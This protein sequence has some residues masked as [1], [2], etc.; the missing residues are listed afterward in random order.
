[1]ASF[2]GMELF[3]GSANSYAVV[4]NIGDCDCSG[5][6]HDIIP[7]GGRSE[8]AG[9]NSQFNGV[10]ND[11]VAAPDWFT[12]TDAVAAV[13]YASESDNGFAMDNNPE[14]GVA[15]TQTAADVGFEAYFMG[16]TKEGQQGE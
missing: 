3:C 8:D 6:N 1:M 15:H 9:V 10:A 16:A 13:E 5:P 11:Q 2:V 7:D 14:R 4:F 12:R